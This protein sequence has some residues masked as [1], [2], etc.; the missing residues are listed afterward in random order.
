MWKIRDVNKKMN[1]RKTIQII[2]DHKTRTEYPGGVGNGVVIVA[3]GPKYGPLGLNCIRKIRKLS[4]DIKIHVFGLDEDELNDESMK[5]MESIDNVTISHLNQVT[6]SQSVGWQCKIKAITSCP[7]ENVL[8]LDADNEPLMP[9]DE[10]FELDCFKTHHA[11]MWR[12]LSDVARPVSIGGFNIYDAWNDTIINDNLIGGLDIDIQHEHESGQMLINRKN[13][14]KALDLI[15]KMNEEKETMYQLVRGDK[16]TYQIGFKVTN[17]PFY[18]VTI[19]PSLGGYI[20]DQNIFQE[21]SLI[22]FHPT[23]GKP[24]F[25]H[26]VG[27]HKDKCKKTTHIMR[28][29]NDDDLFCFDLTKWHS[30]FVNGTIEKIDS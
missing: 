3:G 14:W 1:V 17:T 27:S 19:R 22:Q 15:S 8:L 23:T 6:K 7:F 29:H 18:E 13:T 9:V 25:S 12:D 28:S 10:L 11:V 2:N 4:P 16:D 24:L 26:F 21:T 20:N 30:I 5:E